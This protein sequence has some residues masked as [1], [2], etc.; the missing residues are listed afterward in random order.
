MITLHA[1]ILERN[2]RKAFAVLPY[3]DFVRI[4][5][6]LEN[7]DDLRALRAAKAKEATSPTISLSEAKRQIRIGVR[8][9]H[10]GRRDKA[11]G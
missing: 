5:E 9:S 6:E 4:Q 7:F 10:S 1:N 3:E 11:R 8:T 2:G